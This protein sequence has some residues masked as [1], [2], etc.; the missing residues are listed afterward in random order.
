MLPEGSLASQSRSALAASAGLTQ[1]RTTPSTPVKRSDA[2]YSKP[3]I[4]DRDGEPG[5]LERILAVLFYC[6]RLDFRRVRVIVAD[7]DD[8]P[9]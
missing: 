9:P 8:F 2:V 3:K 6:S 1:W 7:I 4:A 5:I